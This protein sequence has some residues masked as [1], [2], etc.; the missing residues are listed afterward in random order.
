MKKGISRS[1]LL[2][3]FLLMVLPSFASGADPSDSSIKKGVL[4]LQQTTLSSNS[5]SLQG[6]WEFYW[7]ELL[8]PIDFSIG[9]RKPAYIEAPSTWAKADYTGEGLISNEGYGTYRL[10]ILLNEHDTER[11]LS[12]YLP[13]VASAFQIW[14]DGKLIGG[15]G[16]I[17]IDRK[18]MKPRS[19]SQIVSFQPTSNE[20]E[21]VMQVSNFS[22]RKGG[23][24]SA[25]TLGHEK[26]ILKQR[27]LTIMREVLTASCIF[28]LGFYHISLYLFRVTTLLPLFLGI[29]CLVVSLRTLLVG[30]ILFMYIIPNFP[31][32][33][34]VKMEYLTFYVGLLVVFI[35]LA[36]LFPKEMNQTIVRIAIVIC[37]LFSLT[38]LLPAYIFTHFLVFFEAW[39]AIMFIYSVYVVTL[40]TVR[41]REGAFV[42][43]LS[44]NV[45]V[46]AAMNDMLFHKQ[47][48]HSFDLAPIAASIFLFVQTLIVA[49]KSSNAFK[50]VES[51]SQ[52]LLVTNA[53]LEQKVMERTRDLQDKNN[54][55][56]HIEES[57]KSFFSTVSHEI[58]TPM[59]SIQ[60]YIQLMQSKI[61]SDE[62]Q[63]YLRIIF[64]KTKLFN[65]LSKDL[66]D[67]AKLDE[68]QLEFNLE[69]TNVDFFLNHM[70]K[71]LRYDIENKGIH[72]IPV[73]IDSQ[74]NELSLV[75]WLDVMRMEQVLVNLVQNAIA[76][77]PLGGMIEIT[78][79]FVPDEAGSQNGTLFINITDN[80]QGIDADLV[81][82]VFKRFVKGKAHHTIK[83]GS[84]LGLAICMEIVKMHKGAMTVESKA[85]KGSTFTV[86]L[87]AYLEKEADII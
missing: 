18:S 81:P 35:F 70:N 61:Q 19:Y 76:F 43:F 55:L 52:E 60:G 7:D 68:G 23:M 12:L 3:L 42:N 57:R 6:Q 80:G 21:L 64:E 16:T 82:H 15:N 32:E 85:G 77:T 40:A 50:T 65:R 4:D 56:R 59:Q 10:R 38:T 51:L 36:H 63:Q 49:K 39:I 20:V 8:E 14:V 33:L 87:P 28:A 72:F 11:H 25:I 62:I 75:A 1:T 5:L 34:S 71:Q 17:G 48:I 30:G 86:S 31:W 79:S 78:K 29:F 26:E 46:L 53:S 13:S 22:Q 45:L 66:I 73:S 44:I 37:S 27:E 47:L 24:W 2:T 41:K 83:K 9:Q 54:Q 84:G 74:E 67:L 58:A 69:Y